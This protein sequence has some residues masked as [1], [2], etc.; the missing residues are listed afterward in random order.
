MENGCPFIY[1]TA[2]KREETAGLVSSALASGFRAIDTAAQPKHYREDLVGLGLR[3]ALSDL[4]IGR[5][6]LFV[7][8]PLYSSPHLTPVS[9]VKE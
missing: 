3:S 1:G 5:E 7:P 2:W 8:P 4:S 9:Q 6:D